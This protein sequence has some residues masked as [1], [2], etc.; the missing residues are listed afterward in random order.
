MSSAP[1]SIGFRRFCLW[2]AGAAVLLSALPVII[3]LLSSPEGALYLQQQIALDDQMVYA[4]WMQ[5]ASDGALFFDNRFAIEDQPGLTFHAYFLVLGWLS[6]LTGI[7][8]ALTIGRLLFGF[9]FVFLLGRFVGR[10]KIETST[11]RLV[12]VIAVFGG[13]LGFAAWETFGREIL[14]GSLV[15]VV[16][17]GHLPTDVW[18]TEAFVFPSMLVNGLFMI[19][20][21]LILIVLTA[22]LDARESKRAI[23]PGFAA[24]FLLMNIHSYDVLLI[25]LVSVGLLAAMIGSKQ[26]TKAWLGRC[27]II[28]SG[29]ILPAVWFLKVISEDPVFQARA[30][31][32]TY[33]GDFRG[34][35]GGLLPLM[36]LAMLG[37]W[38]RLKDRQKL[39]FYISAGVVAGLY[40]L[41]SVYHP[42]GYLLSGILWASVTLFVLVALCSMEEDRPIHALLWSWALI[43]LT[44]PYFPMLFQRKLSMGM[45]IP[46]AILAAFE[47]AELT[48]RLK[49][50]ERRLA[51]GLACLVLCATSVRWIARELNLQSLN[52]S[53]TTLHS[54]Y[55]SKSAAKAI[56]E[57]R[58]EEGRVVIVASPG[59]PTQLEGGG[60]TEPYLPDLNPMLAGLTGSY[61]FAGHW[62]ETPVYAERRRDALS[63]FMPGISA[64]KRLELIETSE[65]THL[66][67]PLPSAFP[68]VPL[69]DLRQW[70]EVLFVEDEWMLIRIRR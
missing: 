63:I 11:K 53:N 34:I 58:N 9:L 35:L 37:L 70:G 36:V 61:A 62:S 15:S 29:A 46:W 56:E 49:P 13:G 10:F 12:M 1:V 39:G 54:P 3:G 5:Q 43:G 7:P 66:L 25:A 33:T 42:D 40:I 67:A 20:L 2:L 38:R 31:T 27:L 4:A 30:A 55:L 23:L 47:L 57:L 64:E 59:Y 22:I 41:S 45:A 6:K 24:M 14:G 50:S 44:A 8:T 19:S 32:E 48:K 68:K 17:G 60:F 28:G 65:A 18:Q 26:L 69:T 16:T 21:C 51:V 52:V